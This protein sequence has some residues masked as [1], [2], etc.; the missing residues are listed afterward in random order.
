M[1]RSIAGV[2]AVAAAGVLASGCG[3]TSA[4]TPIL[5]DAVRFA[6]GPPVSLPAAPPRA[7]TP[8]SLPPAARLPDVQP[9]PSPA[10]PDEVGRAPVDSELATTFVLCDGVG[11]YLENGYMPGP[12]DWSSMFGGYMLSRIPAYQA[13]QIGEQLSE[14][15]ESPDPVLEA[16]QLSHALS[17]AAL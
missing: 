5:D 6:E 16:A 13:E 17:C 10:L 1:R 15:A 11:F 14:V 9:Q 4:V 3:N 2:V 7:S 8:P 12:G